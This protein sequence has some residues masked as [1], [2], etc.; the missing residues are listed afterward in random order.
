MVNTFY[1]AYISFI[2]LLQKKY[3]WKGLL[4]E[5]MQFATE[6]YST[7]DRIGLGVDLCFVVFVN[8]CFILVKEK[9]WIIKVDQHFI[10]FYFMVGEAG[11]KREIKKRYIYKK[12]CEVWIMF[13]FIVACIQRMEV[14]WP[15]GFQCVRV[16]PAGAMEVNPLHSDPWRP[17]KCMHCSFSGCLPRKQQV[18]LDTCAGVFSPGL[19]VYPQIP[20]L[21]NFEDNMVVGFAVT[22]ESTPLSPLYR[23]RSGCFSGTSSWLSW[24]LQTR[25]TVT[26]LTAADAFFL[27]SN[28]TLIPRTNREP[29]WFWGKWSRGCAALWGLGWVAR[30]HTHTPITRC[31]ISWT[32]S[33]PIFET[34][35]PWP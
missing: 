25:L 21:Q 22:I 30:S 24:Y 34:L 10:Q 28:A 20:K 15:T 12:I 2:V 19:R 7:V 14:Q 4:C 17:T 35:C 8:Y 3:V 5:H 1:Y 9:G 11:F 29:E 26:V 33:L 27:T 18:H 13:S 32:C 31:H 23:M 6:L 16:G